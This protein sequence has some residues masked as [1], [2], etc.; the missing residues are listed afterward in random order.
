M[1]RFNSFFFFEDVGEMFRLATPKLKASWSTG[2][3]PDCAAKIFLS[4]FE[5][6]LADFV[7]V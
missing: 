2:I 1:P 6:F 4:L 3:R 5:Y 7:L